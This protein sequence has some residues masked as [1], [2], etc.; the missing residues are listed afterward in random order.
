MTDHHHM[1]AFDIFVFREDASKRRLNTKY[2]PEIAGD[3]PSG[4]LF[5]LAFARNYSVAR[6][7]GGNVA[8]DCVLTTPFVPFRGRGKELREVAGLAHVVPD[9]HQTFS[10][11][12]GQRTNHYGIDRAE[13]G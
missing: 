2:V 7:C 4:D 3:L 10:V 13:H 5:G 9:H 1:D 12:V 6:L 11:S 8:E